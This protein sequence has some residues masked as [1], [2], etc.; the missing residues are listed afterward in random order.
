MTGPM[1]RAAVE[2][3]EMDAGLPPTGNIGSGLLN[4]LKTADPSIRRN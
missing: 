1:T 2:Q 4:E 3:F